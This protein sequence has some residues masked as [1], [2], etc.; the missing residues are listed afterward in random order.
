MRR[1]P[2]LIAALSLAAMVGGCAGVAKNDDSDDYHYVMETGS[3]LP[4]K[5]KR[6]QTT[7]GSQNIEKVEGEALRQMQRDQ[8]NRRLT[9]PR[10]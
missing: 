5:V 8:T 10:G 3:S 9:G 6:G 2:S 7:D 1:L 4:K